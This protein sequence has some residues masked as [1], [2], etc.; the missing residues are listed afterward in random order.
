[1][2][3]RPLQDTNKELYERF[4]KSQQQAFLRYP[5]DWVVRF[6]NMYLKER[7]PSGR[8]LDYSCGSGNNSIFFLRNGYDLH[9][10]EVAESALGLIRLNLESYDLDLEHLERFQIVPLPWDQLPFED[11]FFDL[12]LCNQVL[13]Y[14]GSEAEIKR[15]CREFWRCLR[16]GGIV[17]FT[18]MGPKN[19]YMV[20]HAKQIHNGKV[21]EIRIDEPNHR[22]DGLREMIY[23]VRDEQELKDLFSDF[24][25]VTTGYFDQS[26]FDM[27]SNFHWIFVGEKHL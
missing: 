11:N 18:V 16:P 2:T 23:L 19:Y 27:K 6:H 12:I 22:L 4:Y 5:A 17:F 13:Y 3:A 24:D 1:M 8:V 7:L 25:C 26:M 10:V 15:V 20:Y 9:G 21:Y 14:L